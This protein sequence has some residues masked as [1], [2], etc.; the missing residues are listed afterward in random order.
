MHFFV[1]V[2]TIL[3]KNVSK[4][5]KSKE[6]SR[7]TVDLNN[8]YTECT[9]CK[10]FR[11]G[12][13]DNLIAKYLKPHKDNYKRR[14]QVCFIERGN[15]ALQKQCDNGDNNNDQKMYASMV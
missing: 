2:P 4:G 12:Y 7:T 8:K 15:R 11:W 5:W 14:K 13:V 6:K 1:E 9:P 3:Q 10:C